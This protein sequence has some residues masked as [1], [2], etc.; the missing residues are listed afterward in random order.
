MKKYKVVFVNRLNCKQYS[1]VFV[2][3]S[4]DAAIRQAREAIRFEE[5][6]FYPHI[7]LL[8]CNEVLY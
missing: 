6:A 5:A 2:A 3:D 4:P 1:A 7:S 8:W